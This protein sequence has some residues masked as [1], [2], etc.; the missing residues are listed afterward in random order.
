MTEQQMKWLASY[1][2]ETGSLSTYDARNCGYGDLLKAGLIVD[3][4]PPTMPDLFITPE[5]RGAV[6]Q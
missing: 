5:G 1:N 4:G 2:R 6:G 3:R